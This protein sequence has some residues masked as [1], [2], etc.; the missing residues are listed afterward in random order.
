MPLYL[1]LLIYNNYK[2]FVLGI[3]LDGLQIALE[4]FKYN[5]CKSEDLVVLSQ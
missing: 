1:V 4:F 3:S 5:I 2:C